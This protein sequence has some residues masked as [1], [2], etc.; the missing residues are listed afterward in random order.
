LKKIHQAIVLK[1][2]WMMLPGLAATYLNLMPAAL[3]ER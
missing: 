2:W 1:P 3:L